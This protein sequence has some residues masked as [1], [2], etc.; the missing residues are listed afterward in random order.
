MTEID[1]TGREA[2][3]ADEVDPLGG[4]DATVVGEFGGDDEDD[5][6]IVGELMPAIPEGPTGS[7]GAHAAI[8]AAAQAALEQPGIPGRDEFLSL[9]MQARIMA[10][11][12]LVP[13]DLRGKPADVFLVLLT[14]RDVGIPV[15]SALRKVYVVDGQPSLAPQL[16][17]ALV[18]RQGLGLVRKAG[19]GNCAWQAAE[20]VGPDGVVLG[21]PITC[22]WRDFAGDLVGVECYPSEDGESIVHSKTCQNPNAK[23]YSDGVRVKCKDNYRNHPRRMLWWRAA[24]YCVDDYFPEVGLGLYSPDELGAITDED[25]RPLDPATVSL[26]EGF[27]QAERATRQAE[28]QARRAAGT[29]IGEQ[30]ADADV[31]ADLTARVAC[32]PEEQRAALATKWRESERLAPFKLAELPASRVAF[33]RSMVQ[34][35][36]AMA[37]R[38]GWDPEA[39]RAAYDEQKAAE[40]PQEP[41]ED[42]DEASEGQKAADGDGASEGATGPEGG[43]G[44][45]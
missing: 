2:D 7:V 45:G 12:S 28:Q 15:T 43:E 22:A 27:E 20:A 40:A 31:L 41:Q 14:G 34:G 17:L 42:R 29:A 11:S 24:G 37:K 9:A 38:A 4:G 35:F 25:G 30:A 5:D 36:E 1:T 33:V 21:E 18:R 10:G 6:P 13:K 16:K 3:A 26:P 32:L 8:E 44:E 19:A 23:P 39:A